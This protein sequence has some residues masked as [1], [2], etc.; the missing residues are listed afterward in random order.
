M[1]YK[2]ENWDPKNDDSGSAANV[3]PEPPWGFYKSHIFGSKF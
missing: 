3:I 1:H 2:R